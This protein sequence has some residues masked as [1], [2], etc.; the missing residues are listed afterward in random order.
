MSIATGWATSYPYHGRP[1]VDIQTA[2]DSRIVDEHDWLT[3]KEVVP[4]A[5]ASSR[6]LCVSSILNRFESA[7][8][9]NEVGLTTQFPLISIDVGPMHLAGEMWTEIRPSSAFTS[10]SRPVR[11]QVW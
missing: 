2:T 11:Q 4:P 3:S 10:F 6:R 5:L 9:G 8:L 7:V 1:D